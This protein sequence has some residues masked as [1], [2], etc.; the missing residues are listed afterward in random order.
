MSITTA[1][2]R[3]NA[4]RDVQA[5]NTQNRRD[6]EPRFVRLNLGR[7]MKPYW[8]RY[9]SKTGTPSACHSRR[10]TE[11]L[12]CDPKDRRLYQ[13]SHQLAGLLIA[14]T[15][16]GLTEAQTDSGSTYLTVFIKL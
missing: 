11:V 3:W 1:T 8:V 15:L 9:N 14:L 16:Q 13:P 4:R 7:T 2:G 10:E 12:I 6:G 5:D